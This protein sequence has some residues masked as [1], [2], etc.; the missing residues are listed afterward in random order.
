MHKNINSI[1]RPQRCAIL[2]N[3]RSGHW[4]AAIAN[5]IAAASEV[6]GGRSFV[7]IPTDGIRI[8]EKFWEILEAYSPDRIALYRITFLDTRLSE[9]KVY[10]DTKERFREAWNSA[11]HEGDFEAWF[12][13]SAAQSVIDEITITD[14]LNNQLLNKLSPFYFQ[15]TAIQDYL[16]CA[17]GFGFPFTKVSDI[18]AHAIDEIHEVVLPVPIEDLSAALLLHSQSGAFSESYCGKLL[19]QNLSVSQLGRGFDPV[20]LIGR[21]LGRPSF[22]SLVARGLQPSKDDIS[23][24]PFNLSMVELGEYY[25][26]RLHRAHKEPVVAILGDTV[27]DFCLYYSLSRLH[28]GAVWLPLAW[29]RNTYQL[30]V[31]N[32]RSYTRGEAVREPNEI[33]RLASVLVDL[34]YDLIEHGS[35]EKYIQLVSMSLNRR[36]LAAYRR[37]II[38]CCLF[39]PDDFALKIR[40]E[41]TARVD[42]TCVM[43]VFEIDNYANHQSVVFIDG[44]SVSPLDTPKPKNF[45][46]VLPSGH[47]WVTSLRIEGYEPL[48]LPSLGAAMIDI[49]GVPL[50]SRVAVDGVAYHCPNM[51]YFGGG[52]DVNLVRPRIRMLDEMAMLGTY[53]GLIGGTIQYSDKGRYLNDTLRR[54]G[55]LDETSA[56][57]RAPSTRQILEKFV[58]HRGSSDGSVIFLQNDQRSYLNLLAFVQSIHDESRAAAL[59]DDLIGKEV[60]QRGY[61]FR[62]ERCRL[63]SWYSI[64]ALTSEFTCTRCSLRQQFTLFHWK[65]PVEA[66][67]YYKLAETIYQFYSNNSHL[68]VQALRH[69]KS[70]SRAAFHYVPE[71]ELLDFPQAGRK[72]E[73][74]IACILDGE[75]VLGECKTGALE[76]RDVSKFETLIGRHV[77]PPRRI[78]FATSLRSVSGAFKSRISTLPGAEVL[79]RGDMYD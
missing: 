41:P 4:R 61:I 39:Q 28:G 76:P 74:D 37:E 62:C 60:L 63:A 13:E 56:F 6:W 36:Q 65:Q 33:Q 1:V 26:S 29:I 51:A 59:I 68:T 75:A 9:P 18:I 5:A 57:I 20:S 52:I 72:R 53:F 32:E 55:G 30:R 12:T 24:L 78:V 3:E 35:G 34:L 10:A 14:E 7:I 23:R 71:I 16:S 21:L 17:G 22:A 70:Q 31:S 8:R 15:D 54:F 11:K 66:R 73:F 47:Y 2:I 45:H 19:E 49:H 43:R 27:E 69:L 42:T 40:C 48:S 64:D 38:A 67:W 50:D 77:K 25:D 46:R 79:T 58:S 44:E